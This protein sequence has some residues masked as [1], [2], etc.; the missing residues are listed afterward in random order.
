MNDSFSELREILKTDNLLQDISD[1]E[2]CYQ[3]L[4]D[5]LRNSPGSGDVVSLVRHILRRE[6]EKQGGSSPSY[7]Q[8]PRKA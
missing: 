5:A 3:R 8:I 6:D 2:A 4:L 7:L 1:M